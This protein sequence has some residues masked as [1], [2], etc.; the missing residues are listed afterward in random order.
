M[1][2]IKGKVMFEKFEK[3]L[4]YFFKLEQKNLKILFQ[5]EYACT[6]NLYH[7]IVSNF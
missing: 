4:M 5:V 3:L 2:N 1:C 7:K 6:T